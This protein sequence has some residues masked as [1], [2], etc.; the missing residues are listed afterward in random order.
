VYGLDIALSQALPQLRPIADIDFEVSVDLSGLRI[1]KQQFIAPQSP[2]RP[3]NSN[4]IN[5]SRS[6]DWICVACPRSPTEILS[7]YIR[8]DG[9]EVISHKPET[10]PISDVESFLLGPILGAVLRLRQRICLHASVME[11]EGKAFAM[12]GD[13]GAGKSTT[14]AALLQ[15]GARLVS[16]DVAVFKID[17]FPAMV[18]PGY[19]GIRLMPD[20]LSSFNLNQ[21]DLAQVVSTSNKRYVPVLENNNAD[22]SKVSWQFQPSP[23]RLHAVYTLNS[24]QSDLDKT[25]FNTLSK[26]QALMAL[27]PHIYGRSG[28]NEMQ[29]E[30]EFAFIAQLSRHITTKSVDRPDNLTHLP[31]IA[32]DIL[33]DV[34]NIS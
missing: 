1:P 16:D 10:I 33:A 18:Y 3:K 5:I 34:R 29:R 28:K 21:N 23:C 32:E 25:Q 7:F 31:K 14:A 12:V 4:E 19:P 20:A 6:Q 13:K 27:A 26:R 24:R 15:A 17:A 2:K 11:H 8:H 22:E 30:E 9:S